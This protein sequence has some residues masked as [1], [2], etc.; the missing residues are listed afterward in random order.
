MITLSLV[1]HGIIQRSANCYVFF[2]RHG[3][4]VARLTDTALVFFPHLEIALKE[5]GFTGKA[6]SSLVLSSVYQNKSITLLFLG[7]GELPSKNQARSIELYR[8]A[9]GKL[10]RTAESHKFSSFT[11]DLPDPAVLNL[12]Y[13]HV[14]Q[15]T[16][17]FLH[18]ASYHFDMF[19]TNVERKFEWPMTA[20]IGVPTD[21]EKAAQEGI[22]KGL[23]FA[24]AINKARYWCDMPPSQLP[25]PVLAQQAADMAREYGLKV[26]ILE[27]DEIVAHNMGGIEGVCRGSMHDPR[28]VIVEY[29]APKKDAPTIAFVGKGVT[30]DTGGL[31]IKPASGMLTMKDDMAGA[32]VVLATMQVIAQ[33]KPEVNVVA[34]APL[35]ENMPSGTAQKPGDVMRAYNGKTVEIIDTDAEGRLILA[36]ALSYTCDV[37]KPDLMID[38]A[39]LT[40][41]CAMALGV[42]YAG[43]FTQDEEVSERLLAS[44]MHSGDQLWRL[45]LDDD[46][47]PAIHSDI[48]DVKNTGSSTYKGG[49]ITAAL[50]LKEFVGKTPWAHIDIAGV[51]FGVPDLTYIRP[52]ATG[53]GIRLLT[54]IAMNWKPLTK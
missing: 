19:I 18:K 2:V 35:V 17:T 22:N 51:A 8:R 7:L 30:F 14:A 53:F 27:K 32:A 16:A 11:F 20:E 37:Y 25:P 40:G 48:A 43:L 26:T 4:D 50:F 47:R 38:V 28:L 45:P 3:F 13:E 42:F 46:Y 5:R 23:C 21:F 36:D 12:S 10:V 24:N 44:S 49:A 6:G 15:E 39:T 54:D 33:F 29:R 9:L 1:T 34:V 31:C 52:G 41:A